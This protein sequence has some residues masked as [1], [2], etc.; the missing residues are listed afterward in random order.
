MDIIKKHW[1]ILQSD[2]SFSET[3]KEFPITSFRRNKNLGDL[4]N[5]KRLKN[6]QVVRPMIRNSKGASKPCYSRKNNKCC[7]QIK[8][9]DTFK[10]SKTGKT[11]S[12][13]E[14]L[15]CKSSWLIYL[16]ECRLCPTMQYIGKSETPVNIRIN[17]HR[18]DCKSPHTIEIDQ[19]FRQTGHDFNKHATFTLIETIKQTDQPKM[20]K[21]EMLEK[22]EDFW[23]MRLQTLKPGGINAK[24]NHSNHY[25]GILCGS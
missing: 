11:Y 13:Y 17:K 19:H 3:F 5:S 12:I 15:S 9:T 21:R 24:L 14:N 16:L 23:I 22:R 10:S 7:Q 18:D 8:A 4:L 20:K 2:S 1:Y 25:T 6:N